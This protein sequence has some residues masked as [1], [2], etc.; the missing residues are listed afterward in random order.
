[1]D[2][3]DERGERRSDVLCLIC[4]AAIEWPFVSVFVGDYN[5]VNIKPWNPEK[6][7]IIC[8]DCYMGGRH[9]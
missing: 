7:Q 1:V 6:N 8:D 9:T 3:T 2:E 5:A 4:E